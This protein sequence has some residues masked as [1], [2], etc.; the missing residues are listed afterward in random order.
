[1]RALIFIGLAALLAVA[2]LAT[3]ASDA[4]AM[5]L[6]M[7]LHE[8]IM[9]LH[10]IRNEPHVDAFYTGGTPAIHNATSGVHIPPL[11]LND[12]PQGFRGPD[13]QPSST[14]W[15]AALTVGASF[16]VELAGKWGN[17]MGRE[18]FDKGANVQLGPGMCVGRLPTNGRLFEYISGEDPFLGAAMVRPLVRGIQASGVIANAKHWV[19]NSQ[20]TE[21][22]FSTSAV[23]ER[24]R[25][26][27]YYPP[28]AAAIQAGVGS[29]MCSYNLI[30]AEG[31]NETGT[32]SC[33][34]DETL[35]GDLKR[36]LNF[37]G[38]VMSD[39]RATHSTSIRS[40]LD[41]EMPGNSF[42]GQDL[43]DAVLNETNPIT[44]DDVNESCLRILTQMYRIGL[45]DHFE[46][47][48]NASNHARDVTSASHSKLAREIAAAG[49]VLLKNEG[50]VLPIRTVAGK[51]VLL[52]GVNAGSN[53][54][55]HGGGSGRVAPTY[56]VSPFDG[57]SRR[58]QGTGVNVLYDD[59][60]N[61]TA[62]AAMSANADYTI[63]FAATD[64]S[65]GMD[66]PTLDFPQEQNALIR[67]VSRVNSA[68]RAGKSSVVVVC[69]NPGPVLT[70]WS[71]HVDAI[72]TMFMPGLEVGNA[73]ADV[74]LGFVNP[75]GRLPVTFPNVDNEQDLSPSQWPGI[76][77]ISM[78]TEQLNVGYRWYAAHDVRPAF[79]FGHGLSYASFEYVDLSVDVTSISVTV[80]NSGAVAGAD[81]PQLY[82]GFPPSSGEPPLQLRGFQKTALLAPNES[83]RVVF[84]LSPRDVSVWDI[85]SHSWL[86]QNGTFRVYV[87]ASS[88]DIRLRGVLVI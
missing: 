28:F 58:L 13:D 8:K 32:W 60:S 31:L 4:Q 15:P 81:V 2:V 37:S 64:S 1:M 9:L 86:V 69:L 73:I 87:G 56:V 66:R 74:L 18:F 61:I 29:I 34:D 24:T 27:M 7:S 43:Y 6:K 33:E 76:D 5:L 39:W 54:T 26:E 41:Q 85:R 44:E 36:R 22:H 45:F 20:E 67:A 50:Y 55:I 14:A 40:G 47:W 19:V 59:G 78:F 77:N 84:D 79:P 3:P 83:A 68:R 30:Q 57:L 10:G 75:A 23:D 65:E 71:A 17:A 63:V 12:G 25:F 72:L 16:D 88:E 21:R 42:M 62:A 35:A 48:E 53:V 11:N 70:T 38:W 80:R 52:L 49:T 82:L 51:S 46:H